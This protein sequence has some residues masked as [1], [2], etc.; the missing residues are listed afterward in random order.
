MGNKPVTDFP[1]PEKEHE[2]VE[3]IIAGTMQTESI[4]LIFK[5]DPFGV[6]RFMCPECKFESCS[7]LMMICHVCE[8]PKK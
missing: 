3:K 2:K 7:G 5:T 1:Y 4:S 8:P 6:A